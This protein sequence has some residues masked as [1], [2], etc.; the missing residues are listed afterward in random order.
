VQG[1]EFNYEWQLIS[2]EM[3]LQI[4]WKMSCKDVIKYSYLF[5]DTS[6]YISKK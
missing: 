6:F 3:I 4:P 5:T 2:E 1:F